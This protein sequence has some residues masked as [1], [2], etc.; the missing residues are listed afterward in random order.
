MAR[1]KFPHPAQALAI[2]R[3]KLRARGA[4]IGCLALALVLLTAPGAAS[5][6]AGGLQ[7]NVVF[8]AYT[9]LAGNAERMRRLLSPLTAWRM[10]QQL[11]QAHQRLSEQAV[12]LTQERFALY[13]PSG[14]PASKG[15]AL[16]VFVS[17]WDEARVP[18]QWLAT[19][20][21]HHTIFVSAAH[22][23]NDIDVLNRRE[24]LALLA[25]YNVM[26]RYHVDPDRIYIGGFSGGSKVALRLALAYPDLFRGVLLEAGSEPIG[27]SAIPLPPADLLH[28]F[29]QSTRVVYLTGARDDYHQREDAHD[30]ESLRDWCMTSLFSVAMPWADHELADAGSFSRALDELAQPAQPDADKLAGCRA[31]HERSLQ[32]Q[33]QRAETLI[34][35][36]HP[37][38]ARKQLE[39]VD[40]SYGGL[41]GSRV[42]AL[43]ERLDAVD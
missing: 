4:A 43:M 26:Q 16:L 14:A 37:D 13:V 15:Y 7:D 29:Q 39:R 27:T 1:S 21:R 33:L 24:P 38:E 10:Q 11:R 5:P 36:G 20:E 31:A 22:S 9:Q 2:H 41:A 6:A 42:V 34:D 30:R 35:A 17:P 40:A 12:D 32:S 28:Y 18:R 3:I 8:T 19:L 25:V 23:G